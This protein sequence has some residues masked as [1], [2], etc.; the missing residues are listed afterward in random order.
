MKRERKSSGTKFYAISAFEVI[1]VDVCLVQTMP[2][3][4][5]KFWSY[6]LAFSVDSGGVLCGASTGA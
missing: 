1:D 2:M 4:E 5:A 6:G 3:V